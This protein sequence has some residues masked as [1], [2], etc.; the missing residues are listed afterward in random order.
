MLKERSGRGPAYV[1]VALPDGRRRAGR[2]AS[3]DIAET[4]I[5]SSPTA[6]DLPCISARKLIDGEHQSAHFTAPLLLLIAVTKTM[7]R[8]WG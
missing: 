3:T 8:N 2:I 6:A 7:M 4:L 1:V 5:T